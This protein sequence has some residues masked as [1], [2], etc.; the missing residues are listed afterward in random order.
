M[1]DIKSFKSATKMINNRVY[2]DY[3]YRLMLI[4]KSLF[5]W[6]NLPDGIDERFIERYL[7]TEG[8]C[9]FFKDDKLG[10]MVTKVVNNGQ[11]NAYLEPTRVRPFAY[12]YQYDGPELFNNENCV[13]IKN[14]DDSIPTFPTIDLYAFKLTDIDMTIRTNIMNQKTPVVITCS[15]KQKLSL[16][17]VINQRNENE[18]A[19]YGDKN[20]DMNQINVLDLR[21]PVVFD[22]LQIQKHDIWN[23]CMT[24]LGINNAN[25]DKRERLVA[26]EVSANDE[27]VSASED[28]MLKARQHC[29]DLINEMFG[30][31]IKVSRR[32][33]NEGAIPTQ[34]VIMSVVKDGE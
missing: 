34:E 26:D 22:K 30:L 25:Q 24:F 29:A 3:F 17:N 6:E 31:D 19:I 15:D 27:Q 2:T 7:F 5:K 18:Y 20:L 23:E 8:Q 21:S 33:M 1:Y 12:N 11:Y 10:F 13:I 4:S 28:V 16:K 14:N 32:T 9:L